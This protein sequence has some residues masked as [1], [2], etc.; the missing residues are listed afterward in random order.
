MDEHIKRK[1]DKECRED[2]YIAARKSRVYLRCRAGL[3]GVTE[4]T[5]SRCPVNDPARK[6]EMHPA[7]LGEWGTCE[8]SAPQG[9]KERE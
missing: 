7:I 4:W 6:H 2:Y 8:H 9:G 1:L 3:M 5:C